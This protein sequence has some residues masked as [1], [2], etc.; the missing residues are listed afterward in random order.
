LFGVH[1][2]LKYVRGM[3]NEAEKTEVTMKKSGVEK[4]KWC[5]TYAEQLAHSMRGSRSVAS[6]WVRFSKCVCRR[7]KEIRETGLDR[8]V[9]GTLEKKVLGKSR[10]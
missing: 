2:R 1:G 6:N 3:W 8:R 7:W 9:A 5:W 10:T 4:E